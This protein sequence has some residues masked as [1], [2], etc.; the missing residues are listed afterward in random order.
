[1]K[2]LHIPFWLYYLFG[3]VMIV[4]LILHWQH[5]LAYAPFLF[6]LLC[7]LMHLF[8]GHGDHGSHKHNDGQ[9]QH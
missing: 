8:H 7:P 6:I 4:G 1:M 9:H 5:V 3:G 2:T